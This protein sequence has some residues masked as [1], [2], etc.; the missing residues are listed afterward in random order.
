M[1]IEV[2]FNRKGKYITFYFIGHLPATGT[3]V[4]EFIQCLYLTYFASDVTPIGLED[5][6]TVRGINLQSTDQ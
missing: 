2:N 6:Q 4:C 1:L 5:K 3:A